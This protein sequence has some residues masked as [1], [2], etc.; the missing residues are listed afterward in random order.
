MTELD[1]PPWLGTVSGKRIDL[2]DPD[3]NQICIEDIAHALSRIPRF[4]GHL[5]RE[6]SI[7]DHSLLVADLVA[8]PYKLQALL[9]DATEAYICDIPSPL[10]QL[11]GEPYAKIEARLANAIGEAFGVDL[12]NLPTVIKQADR[13]A[14][15]SEREAFQPRSAEWGYDLS[16]GLRVRIQK[17]YSYESTYNEFLKRY[18]EY[19]QG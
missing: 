6:W 7:G 18:V 19:T 14:L 11:L 12:T 4:G 15:M 9:H 10:K 1:I 16:H 17:Y 5:E 13:V 8:K 3:P 2:L